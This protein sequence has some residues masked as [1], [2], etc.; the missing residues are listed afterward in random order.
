MKPKHSYSNVIIHI[1][2]EIIF[3]AINAMINSLVP[4]RNTKIKDMKLT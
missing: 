1:V 2:K 3:L 4:I